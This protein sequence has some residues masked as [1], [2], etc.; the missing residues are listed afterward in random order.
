MSSPYPPLVN[1]PLLADENPKVLTIRGAESADANGDG[2][3]RSFF[4]ANAG[5]LGFGSVGTERS[6]F[7]GAEFGANGEKL[8]YGR[9]ENPMFKAI[10][11]KSRL[12]DVKKSELASVVGKSGV[13]KA[14]DLE[15]TEKLGSGFGAGGYGG[16]SGTGGKLRSSRR[17]SKRTP[18]DRPATGRHATA[19]GSAAMAATSLPASSK[20]AIASRLRDSA[21]RLIHSSASYLFSALFKRTPPFIKANGKSPL[22]GVSNAVEEEISEEMLEAPAKQNDQSVV[23][24]SQVPASVDAVA[25]P[26]EAEGKVLDIVQVEEILKQKT[27][28]REQV[29]RLTQILQ[30]RVSGSDAATPIVEAEKAQ[31]QPRA[32]T[33]G[34]SPIQVARAYMGEQATRP[35]GIASTARKPA[36]L[37]NEVEASPVRTLVVDRYPSSPFNRNW[38]PGAGSVRIPKRSLAMEDDFTSMGPVRRVRQKTSALTNASPYL[39]S[40][41]MT[42]LSKPSEMRMSTPPSQ[43]SKTAMKILETLEKLSPSP[44]GKLLEASAEKLPTGLQFLDKFSPSAK[45]K[46]SNELFGVAGTSASEQNPETS[47]AREKGVAQNLGLRVSPKATESNLIG[48]PAVGGINLTDS[49]AVTEIPSSIPESCN[50]VP[51][52]GKG[53]RMNAVFEESNSDEEAKSQAKLH[54]SGESRDQAAPL[55]LREETTAT[56][57][58]FGVSTTTD[59]SAPSTSLLPEPAQASSPS[60]FVP[61]SQSSTASTPL[62]PN[63]VEP[64]VAAVFHEPT[65]TSASFPTFSFPPVALET[66]STLPDAAASLPAA[67]V[68]SVS[69]ENVFRVPDSGTAKPSSPLMFAKPTEASETTVA[70]TITVVSSATPSDFTKAGFVGTAAPA[71]FGNA[72][73][74]TLGAFSSPFPTTSRT[75]IT[76]TGLPEAESALTMAT[77]SPVAEKLAEVDTMATDHM[78][79]EADTSILSPPASSMPTFFFNANSQPSPLSAFSFAAGASDSSSSTSAFTFGGGLGTAPAGASAS[80]SSAPS[81]AFGAPSGTAF[82]GQALNSSNGESASLPSAA[83]PFTFGGQSS[84]SAA[85]QAPSFAVGASASSSSVAPF[86]FGAQSGTGSGGQT[87]SFGAKPSI[88]FGQSAGAGSSGQAPSFGALPSS[89]ANPFSSTAGNSSSPFMFGSST[90]AVFGSSSSSSSTSSVFAASSSAAPS[91]GGASSTFQFGTPPTSGPSSTTTVSF[92]TSPFSSTPAPTLS[93]TPTF[94]FGAGAASAQPAGS[95]SSGQPFAFGASQ[96]NPFAANPFSSSATQNSA[97]AFNFGA[98]VMPATLSSPFPSASSASSASMFASNAAPPNASNIFA[99]GST[100]TPNLASPFAFGSGQPAPVQAP[101]PAAP[102]AFGGQPAAVAPASEQPFGFNGGQPSAPAPNPF[103]AA[104]AAQPGLGGFALGATGG[105]DKSGRKFIKAKRMGGKKG[106]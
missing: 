103:S 2:G 39:Y 57:V 4:G 66:R 53:F 62:L 9:A 11:E 94:P 92:T 32:D 77:E 90:P 14:E 55:N 37:S 13:L 56:R 30:T 74:N 35:S 7:G 38:T 59:V 50:I 100:S 82:A 64:V 43:S 19:G 99:F 54:M 46:F 93:T 71:S 80:S 84:A 87:P 61:K 49:E 95:A 79:E 97:P 48:K 3:P 75:L 51:E 23:L 47:K 29:N 33:K 96:P 101:T 40:R 73:T 34:S 1:S 42:G 83:G 20:L 28:S 69:L 25:K 98:P 58:S 106:K 85:G 76:H 102:F 26:T 78:A 17:G 16:G 104:G 18:Y 81:F 41:R 22:T 27:W 89:P 72:N 86:A 65:K 8:G 63:K 15:E 88:L 10:T 91:F 5:R 45:G 60:I 24:A 68:V 70:S 67:S 105:G 52:S 21:S 31:E 12:I 44:Q 6:G 36:F